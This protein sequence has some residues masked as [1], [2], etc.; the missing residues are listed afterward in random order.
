MRALETLENRYGASPCSFP[1]AACMDSEPLQIVE[2][3]LHTLQ[4]LLKLTRIMLFQ[5][6][7]HALKF[8]C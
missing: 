6:F 7:K 1:F 3:G 5:C 8:F 2:K 4:L